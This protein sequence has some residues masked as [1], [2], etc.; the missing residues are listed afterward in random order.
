MEL[1]TELADICGT[2][3]LTPGTRTQGG[4][5]YPET[6][7]LPP[8]A[9]KQ[10]TRTGMSPKP[11]S[12]GLEQAILSRVSGVSGTV[13]CSRGASKTLAA[14]CPSFPLPP[15][16]PAPAA[17]AA[18]AASRSDR[19]PLRTP[20]SRHP[21]RP[22]HPEVPTPGLACPYPKPKSL[23]WV[24]A[25]LAVSKRVGSGPGGS[26]FGKGD[27]GGET[28]IVRREGRARE[29]VAAESFLAWQVPPVPNSPWSG[30]LPDLSW[31]CRRGP[32]DGEE[33]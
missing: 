22:G 3:K 17:A 5:T 9:S 8:G 33:G 24:L 16:G 29:P 7:E 10:K 18:S 26:A 2:P 14:R 13:T 12:G 1:R 31:S 4:G 32:E 15:P 21:R 6:Q 23:S 11:G 20:E 28:A 25:H 27:G 19:A 30:L